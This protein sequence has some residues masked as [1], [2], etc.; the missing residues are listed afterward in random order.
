[1]GPLKKI[2]RHLDNSMTRSLS[3]SAHQ[4]VAVGAIAFLGFPLFYFIWM[5][6]FPQPYENLLLRLIG[7][8]LGLGL[9]LTFYWPTRCKAYLSWYWFCTILYTL[10]FFF[11][12]LFLMSKATVISAMSLLCSVF[13][14]VLLVDLLSLLIVLLLGFGLALVAYYFCSPDLYVWSSL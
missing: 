8:I 4:L 6:W 9:M 10:P 3:H 2:V 11:T 13:L 14:L 12:F 5:Y 1:M 7:S